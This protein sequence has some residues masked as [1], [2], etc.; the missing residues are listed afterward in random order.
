MKRKILGAAGTAVRETAFAYPLLVLFALFVVELSPYY[1]A[2]LFALGLLGG[3]TAGLYVKRGG[4]YALALSASIVLTAAI[5]ISGGMGSR[6]IPL[7]ALLAVAACRG[8]Y[9]EFSPAASGRLSTLW[10]VLGLC[11][12]LGVYFLALRHGLVRPY[13]FSILVGA[14]TA[15]FALMLRWNAA[16]VRDTLGIGAD[17]PIPSGRLLRVNLVFMAGL[18]LL[19]LIVGGATQIASVLEWLYRVWAYLLGGDV[20]GTRTPPPDVP[21]DTTPVLKEYCSQ[22]VHNTEEFKRLCS[23]PGDES[24]SD[25]GRAVIWIVAGAAGL[26][27]LAVVYAVLNLLYGILADWLPGWLKRFLEM[28]RLVRPPAEQEGRETYIDTTEKLTGRPERAAR[29]VRR[30]YAEPEDA[31]RRAYWRLVREA[32]ARGYKFRPQL[33]PAETGRE[34][35]G[36]PDYAERGEEEIHRV[37]EGYNRSRY[38]NESDRR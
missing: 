22:P 19:I 15:L 21:I 25:W 26:V 1:A 6:A 8:V 3:G 14:L 36:N 33:T 38:D 31:P 23:P 30:A 12:A 27:V 4:A 5:G 11:A 2:A 13:A 16:R 29:S 10:A 20:G 34:I 37:I 17:D 9:R 24:N 28:L 18:L 32:I 35:A 7:F